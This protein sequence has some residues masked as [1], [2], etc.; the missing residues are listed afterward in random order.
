M[1]HARTRAVAVAAAVAMALSLLVAFARPAQAQDDNVATKAEIIAGLFY[2]ADVTITED[3]IAHA[4]AGKNC[5]NDIGGLTDYKRYRICKMKDMGVWSG[6]NFYPNGNPDWGQVVKWVRK[7]QQWLNN[8]KPNRIRPLT[9]RTSNTGTCETYFTYSCPGDSGERA[10]IG[11]VWYHGIGGFQFR[12]GSS[13]YASGYHIG[14]TSNQFDVGR[15]SWAA[16]TD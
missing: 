16:R 14:A 5:A 12:N 2:T 13:P 4:S 8:N 7:T 3:N 1:S 9:T 6:S 10:G 11:F 15:A